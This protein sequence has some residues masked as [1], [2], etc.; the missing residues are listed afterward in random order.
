MVVL[1]TIDLIAD[2]NTQ[3]LAQLESEMQLDTPKIGSVFLAK[4]C[5]VFDV[6]DREE[7]D[8]SNSIRV[9]YRCCIFFLPLCS[10]TISSFI[11]F[12]VITKKKLWIH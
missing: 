7:C 5:G 4:V 1:S 9:S 12:S 3:L 10:W 11:M 6:R 2:G 8:V